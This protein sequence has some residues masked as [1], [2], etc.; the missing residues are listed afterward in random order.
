MDEQQST[1]RISV[2]IVCRN[3]ITGIRRTLTSIST[4]PDLASIE[5]IVVDNASTDGSAQI[6]S[7]FPFVKMLRMQRNFGWTRAAN[8]GTRT[9]QGEFLCFV[10][11]G[12]EFQ[13]ETITSLEKKLKEDSSALAVCPFVVDS[14]RQPLT[15]VHPLPDA[16]M[17]RQFWKTGILGVSLPLDLTAEAVQADY[18]VNAPFFIRRLSIAGMNFLDVRYGQFWADAEICFQIRRAGKSIVVLPG[19][20]VQDSNPMP[21]IPQ[22]LDRQ[23]AALSADAALG[24]AAYLG[25]HAGMLGALGFRLGAITSAAISALSFDGAK[26]KRLIAIVSSQKIDGTQGK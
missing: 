11:P 21:L 6:D 1:A 16:A 10:R 15:S 25:K 9:A 12:I 20:Q 2:L 7:E 23:S 4:S 22:P 8:A 13:P 18:V 14:S 17:I 3:E 5:V 19:V 24:G 26:I